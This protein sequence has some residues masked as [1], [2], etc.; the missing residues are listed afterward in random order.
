VAL[1]TFKSSQKFHTSVQMVWQFISNP[2]N[3]KEITPDYM[4]FEIISEDLPLNIYPGMI[5]SY[6]VKPLAGIKTLWVTEITHVKEGEYFTDEQRIGPYSLWHHEHRL[7]S[8]PNGVLMED[9]V[10]YAPPLGPIG[11]LADK[12]FIRKKLKEIFDYRE[13]KLTEKFGK[14]QS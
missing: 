6:H 4:G 2:S 10:S 5:I 11:T 1:C 12:L 3:L 13:A 7:R 8:I 9:L 14:F